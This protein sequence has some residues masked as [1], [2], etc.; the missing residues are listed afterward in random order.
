MLSLSRGSLFSLSFLSQFA[1]HKHPPLP[2]TKPLSLCRH[3][4]S[5]NPSRLFSILTV[6]TS[7]HGAIFEH[8][9]AFTVVSL[10]SIKLMPETEEEKESRR[11]HHTRRAKRPCQ[12]AATT[13]P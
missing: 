12:S 13:R 6:A 8:P 11:C 2:P 5:P 3:R 9:L 4:D 1:T 7:N 10:F